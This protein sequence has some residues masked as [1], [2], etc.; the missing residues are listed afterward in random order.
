MGSLYIVRG[1]QVMHCHL[2]EADFYLVLNMLSAHSVAD[3]LCSTAA[4]A[5]KLT[6]A[7]MASIT[8]NIALP[9]SGVTVRRT[10]MISQQPR[11]NPPNTNTA[12]YSLMSLTMSW[13]CALQHA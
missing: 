9:M 10:L 8:S 1:A 4:S 3:V 13:A 5:V 7:T 6:L 2:P 11:R 12:Q